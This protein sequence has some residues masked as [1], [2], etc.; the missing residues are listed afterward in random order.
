MPTNNQSNERPHR[1]AAHFRTPEEGLQ[2][3]NSAS[4]RRAPAAAATSR[5]A[6]RPT[7]TR[8]ASSPAPGSTGAIG[9]TTSHVSART[10]AATRRAGAQGR[11]RRRGGNGRGTGPKGVT[12]IVAVLAG[13]AAFV[14]LFF[15]LVLHMGVAGVAWAT[16]ICQG[17]SCVMALVVVMKR[18]GKLQVK[19]KYQL[20]ALSYPS[21]FWPLQVP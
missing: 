1:R 16:L 17:V 18:V 4:P 19:E 8:R 9:G 3:A 10:A 12:V 21:C 5:P 7:A 11:G 13:V 6:S 2:E 15:V 20:R 14:A